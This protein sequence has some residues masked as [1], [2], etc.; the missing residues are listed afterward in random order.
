M[1][2]YPHGHGSLLMALDEFTDPPVILVLRG[3][4]HEM[5]H[6]RGTLDRLYDP[7][8]MVIA[9][10]AAARDL[11][12][13]LASKAAPADGSTVAYVCRGPTCSAPVRSVAAL[14]ALARG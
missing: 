12:E 7:R 2:R 5:A 4:P 10:P 1:Q 8:R 6:W 9:V 13:A 3:D 11:P 14:A